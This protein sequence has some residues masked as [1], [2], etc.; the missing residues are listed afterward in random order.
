MSIEKSD[1][2]ILRVVE[3]SNTSCVVTAFTRDFGKISGLAKGARRPKSPFEAALDVLSICHLVFVHKTSDSLD[4]LTEAKLERRFRAA[5]RDLTRFYAAYYL[6]ELVLALTDPSDPQP[7]L[8]DL[9]VSALVGLDDG[10]EVDAWVLRFELRL[11]SLIG[12]A[13]SLQQCTICGAPIGAAAPFWFGIASG[14]LICS[15]CRPGKTQVV[16][17]SKQ[18][19]DVLRV[20]ARADERWR[21]SDPWPQARGS[22]RGLMGQL[23]AY[24]LG[25]RPKLSAFLHSS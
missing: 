8:Y 6:V 4:V 1:A 15:A 22:I 21:S 14:G 24:R 12:H 2:V 20:F 9:L 19:V 17:L 16:Q 7:E 5:A 23:I 25:Y 10:D 3:F 11:L 18:A 13:P